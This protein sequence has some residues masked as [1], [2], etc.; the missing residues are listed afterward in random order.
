MSDETAVPEEVMKEMSEDS[1]FFW[2]VGIVGVLI[3]VY[4][5]G[6]Q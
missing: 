2:L 4:F 1:A 5:Q 3:F 6:K